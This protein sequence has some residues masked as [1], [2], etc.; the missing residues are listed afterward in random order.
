LVVIKQNDWEVNYFFSKSGGLKLG[1]CKYKGISV[2]YR[3]SVPFFYVKYLGDEGPFTDQLKSNKGKIVKRDIM[4]GFD[5]KK[6]YYYYGEDYEYD[7]IWRFHEDGQC[8]CSIVIEGPGEENDG[9]HTYHIPFRYDLDVGGSSGDSFQRWVPIRSS[10]G[11][12]SDVLTEGRYTPA[13][14]VS[15]S[16]DWQIVDKTTNRRVMIRSRMGDNA[17]IWPLRY[18]S[19]ED[20][21]TWG[22]TQPSPEYK[23][24]YLVYCTFVF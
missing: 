17:E 14:T 1:V 7:H 19:S 22:G 18:S 3:A 24:S 9:L 8:G 6:I 2:I 5:I 12:W 15:D 23:Y 13:S 4:N 16:Y 11:Y 20:W 21:N 10:N